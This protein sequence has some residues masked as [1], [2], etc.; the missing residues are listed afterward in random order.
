MLDKNKDSV[1][2][3]CTNSHS[4]EAAE[5]TLLMVEHKI[6]VMMQMYHINLSEERRYRSLNVPLKIIENYYAHLR[7]GTAGLL[8]YITE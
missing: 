6:I 1:P 4:C 5:L 7:S 3:L 8:L 2:S